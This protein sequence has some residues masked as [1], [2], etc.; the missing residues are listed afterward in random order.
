MANR[1]AGGSRKGASS[2]KK[3]TAKRRAVNSKSTK[4]KKEIKNLVSVDESIKDEAI[5]L[6]LLGFC[7]LIYLALFGALSS[8][9]KVIASLFYGLFGIVSFVLPIIVFFATAFYMANRGRGVAYVKAVSAIVAIFIFSAFSE[10]LFDKDFKADKVGEYYSHCAEVHRGGG[11]FG[12]LVSHMLVKAIGKPGTY[13]LLIVLAIVCIVL[14]TERSFFTG[15]KNGS[16]SIYNSAR[17]NSERYREYRDERRRTR[18]VE[19]RKKEEDRELKRKDK[20]VSGVMLNTKLTPSVS[21]SDDIHE[22]SGDG[23]ESEANLGDSI[24]ANINI[25][26]VHS[27]DYNVY[28][29]GEIDFSDVSTEETN[30]PKDET[31]NW[32]NDNEIKIHEPVIKDVTEDY[33][34]TSES[35]RVIDS[36]PEKQHSY[37]QELSHKINITGENITG[38]GV[39]KEQEKQTEYEDSF[40]SSDNLKPIA[41]KPVRKKTVYKFPPV[42]MLKPGR[43]NENT[44][45]VA[46]LRETAA[47]LQNTLKTFGV[48]VTI[49]DIAQGPSVTRYEMQPEVG[50]KVSKITNLQDDI[51]LNMAAR[52][53]RIEAPIPGKAAVGIEIPNKEVSTVSFRD[54][55]ESK[56]FKEASSK[57]SFAVGKDLSGTTVVADIGKM[58][59]MLIAGATGSGKSVCINTLIMSIIYKAT[60]DEVKLIMVD[61]KVV[62]LSVYNGIPHLMIPVVTDPKKASAALNWG[63]AEMTDRYNKFAEFG[64]RDLKGYNKKLESTYSD[65]PESERPKK[66]PQIVIIVDE[67][68]DL[69]MVASNEVES[70]ICRLAQLARAAG[71]HLII[72]TQRPSVDVIT[73]LIKA[74]MPSRIAFSVSSGVDSRTIL[75]MNGAERLLGKGDMLFYP[76]GYTKPSRVQGAFIS[77][78]EI[79]E[80]VEFLKANS[81][82]EGQYDEEVIARVNAAS[83]DSSSA[84]G[85][86]GVTASDSGSDKDQYFIEAA[87]LAIE[88]DKASIGY[89]QRKFKIGFNRAA[90]I[91]DQLYEAGVVSAEEGTKPRRV[92]MSME[93]FENALEQGEF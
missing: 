78:E 69:M 72:A 53:I 79:S 11:F 39:V 8:F 35:D 80:I 88:Q 27:I 34:I 82:G 9:G 67:L 43:K 61:P 57:I 41:K 63:V 73:G 12:G 13:I 7:I 26:T 18:E 84:S 45:S 4:Q 48:N 86:S 51:K 76:Q 60:P 54:L 93:Q 28:V 77:D 22:I 65:L 59:H 21:D 92:L 42:S 64:V 87:R 25:K 10:L 16:T 71:I 62:E 75:D 46:E 33:E 85:V 56:E 3:G 90:R 32:K 37:E 52:D 66:L 19:L 29:D 17:D 40:I 68:A 2:S 20:V 70:A 83:S 47:R 30:T 44:E 6:C 24:P 50:T 1:S 58:P 55:L 49:T 74:N 91:M 23:T 81:G 14:I 15:V 5:L 38:H 31:V 36:E 89:F